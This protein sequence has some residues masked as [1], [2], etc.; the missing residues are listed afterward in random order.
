MRIYCYYSFLLFRLSR[1]E[2]AFLGFL[3]NLTPDGAGGGEECLFKWRGGVEKVL[4]VTLELEYRKRR[5]EK[6]REKREG[7]R[8]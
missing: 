1:N 8:G 2:H 5:A 3:R 7:E 6:G 4:K